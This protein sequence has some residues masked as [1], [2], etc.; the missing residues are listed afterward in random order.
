M[1]ILR[2]DFNYNKNIKGKIS[3]ISDLYLYF[4]Q[5]AGNK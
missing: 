5:I 1:K 2:T 3:E 4:F